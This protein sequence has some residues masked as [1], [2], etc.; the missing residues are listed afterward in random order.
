MGKRGAP[1]ALKQ[2]AR[3]PTTMRA[4]CP[5][6]T[7][8]SADARRSMHA[9]CVREWSEKL[10]DGDSCAG[11]MAG[12]AGPACSVADLRRACT[13]LAGRFTVADAHAL[14]TR[15]DGAHEAF[16]SSFWERQLPSQ[17]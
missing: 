14:C 17:P 16:W 15:L 11:Y 5:L 3:A 12:V 1:P 8:P 2:I 13:D 10:A 4:D 7:A 6:A 9:A